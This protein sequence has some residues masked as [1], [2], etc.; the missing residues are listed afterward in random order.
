MKKGNTETHTDII[1]LSEHWA[2]SLRKNLLWKSNRLV[3]GRR[4]LIL[5]NYAHLLKTERMD[6]SK[7]MVLRHIMHTKSG[8]IRHEI[9]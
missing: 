9:V 8:Y 7:V 2:F 3:L 4:G 5:E 6:R 1:T